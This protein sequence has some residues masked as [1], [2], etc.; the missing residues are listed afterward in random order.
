[1]NCPNCHGYK[2][3][4]YDTRHTRETVMRKRRCLKCEYRFYTVETYMT[5]EE[6]EYLQHERKELA[7]QIL[8]GVPD[9]KAAG[10]GENNSVGQDQTMDVSELFDEE[11][12]QSIRE[13]NIQ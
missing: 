1:M 6:L 13:A 11:E 3:S 4:I 2:L 9:D 10:R 5:E 12:S 7:K 8:H